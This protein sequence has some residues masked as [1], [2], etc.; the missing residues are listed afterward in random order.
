MITKNKSLA[1]H[2]IKVH[3]RKKISG[4][5]ERPRLCVYRSLN[6]IYA[7]IIDD[8]A[9]ATLVHSST[10]EKEIADIAKSAKGMSERAKIVGKDIATKA[11]EKNITSVVFD[12]SGYLFHGNVKALADGARENGLKF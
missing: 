12:R 3:V 4:T 9:G 5:A 11:K 1:R 10:L 6:H 2:K 8:V 7:Q